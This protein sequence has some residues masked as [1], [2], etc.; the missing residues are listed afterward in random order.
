M[1]VQIHRADY[2]SYMT[3]LYAI[4]EPIGGVDSHGWR[5]SGCDVLV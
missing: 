2:P 1:T 3:Y 5:K 4:C